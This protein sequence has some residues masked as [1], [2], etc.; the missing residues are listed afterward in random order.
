MGYRLDIIN[1][2]K[3]DFENNLTIEN[4]YNVEPAQVIIGIPRPETINQY[5]TL[6]IYLI[7]DVIVQETLDGSR[8]RVANI[9]IIGYTN[10]VEDIYKLSEDV[11]KFLYSTDFTY[12]NNT[13]LSETGSTFSIGGSTE[14]TGV[15]MFDLQ[16]EIN[17]TQ[18]FN[19]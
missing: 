1:N 11:E 5:P 19:L 15:N 12:G 2:I 6:C 14:A 3:S 8:E 10:N 13:M 9:I 7:N 18:N 16:F 17:Y 4:N